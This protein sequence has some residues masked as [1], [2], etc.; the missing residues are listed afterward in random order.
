M[1][2]ENGNKKIKVMV[3]FGGMSGEHTI[4]CATASGVVSNINKDKYDVVPVGITKT[5]KWVKIDEDMSNFALSSD[6]KVQVPDSELEVSITPT[7]KTLVIKNGEVV[8][9]L[10]KIDVVLPLLHGPFGEDGTLQ[11]YLEMCNMKYVGC[12]VLSSAA[13][14]DKHYTKMILAGAGLPIGPYTVIT[15]LLWKKDPQLAMDQVSSIGFP[16][17]VKPARAG[18]SLGISRVDKEEDLKAAI[19]A[20]REVDPK[21]I[22]EGLLTGREIESAVL[23]GRDGLPRVAHVGELVMDLPE[24]GFYDYENKYLDHGNVRIECP[25]LLNS[26]I[27][28]KIKRYAGLAFEALDCE[29]IAR[30][31]FFY[32]SRGDKIVINEVNTM[33]GFTPYSMYPVMWQETGM[34]YPELVEE[35]I[36]LALD[37]PTG[38]R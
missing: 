35:L 32:D 5:G 23:Q 28:E 26:D 19:L 31:D 21:V 37:R 17:F 20:A 12:G 10:G 27:A 7:G 33:P 8:E 15:D 11:G 18:S 4:S 13:C 29:G 22:V 1:A 3:L 34:S 6:R 24:N 9:N 25:A 16:V 38:L 30:V 2:T 36:E 14:M